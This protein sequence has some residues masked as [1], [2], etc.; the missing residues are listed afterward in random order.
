MGCDLDTR[1]EQLLLMI[2]KRNE[3]GNRSFRR[4]VSADFLYKAYPPLN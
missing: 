1:S 2:V 4:L 3:V